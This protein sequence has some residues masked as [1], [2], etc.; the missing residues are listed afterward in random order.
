[1]VK[2]GTGIKRM[3]TKEVNARKTDTAS[4]KNG[5]KGRG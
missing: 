4:N 1:M 3:N 2:E 5:V